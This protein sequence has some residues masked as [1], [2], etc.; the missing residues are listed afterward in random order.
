M[1]IV[2]QCLACH[3]VKDNHSLE[4]FAC[5][6]GGT[7]KLQTEFMKA[8]VFQPYFDR[9]LKKYICSERERLKEMR[10]FGDSRGPR[11]LRDIRDNYKHMQESANIQRHR[12]DFKASTWPGYKPRTKAQIEKQGER[13]YVP[14]APDRDSHKPRVYSF[15]R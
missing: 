3:T 13:G 2:Y 9:T 11:P 6:C 4:S 10:S 8:H 14:E 1:R 15:G 12:E 7:Y 5:S